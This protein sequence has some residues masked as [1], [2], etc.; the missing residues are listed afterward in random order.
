MEF[1]D[2]NVLISGGSSGIGLELSRQ[3]ATEGANISIFARTIPQLENAL[4]EIQKFHPGQHSV[5]PTD[6]SNEEQVNRSV[7]QL[8]EKG[9]YPDMVINSAGEV[10]PGYTRD[11]DLAT[12]HWMMDVNYFGTVNLTKAVLPGML[13]RGAGHIVNIASM[14]AVI[15]VVGYTAYA[16][17][18]FALRG[19]SDALRMELKPHGIHVSIVYPADTDTPQ[20][21]YEN[22]FKPEAWKNILN[23]VPATDPVPPEKVARQILEGIERNQEV[24]IPDAGMKLIFKSINILGKGVFPVL[25]W[26][27]NRA[28]KQIDKLNQEHPPDSGS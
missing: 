24:I 7:G 18:K 17:S 21:E 28:I 26:L 19:F 15:G 25:D 5:F 12:Y 20:L 16:A 13:E 9:W 8:L 14:M 3:L 27:H 11:L 6:V 22:R 1:K 23:F 10:Q 2:R 4:S